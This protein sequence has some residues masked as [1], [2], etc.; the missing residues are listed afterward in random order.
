M[1]CYAI[2]R[3]D[4]LC[5]KPN[6]SFSSGK[7][8]PKRPYKDTSDTSQEG[9][10]YLQRALC[11]ELRHLGISPGVTLELG[12]MCAFPSSFIKTKTTKKK[13]S[14]KESLSTFNTSYSELGES[15]FEAGEVEG[16]GM[17]V[18]HKTPSQPIKASEW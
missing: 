9:S 18:V 6:G 14:D 11:P 12:L 13:N 1:P 8:K 15:K 3:V 16:E 7:N 5:I 10:S 4:R 2:N 17:E